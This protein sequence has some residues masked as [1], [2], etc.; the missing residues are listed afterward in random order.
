MSAELSTGQATRQDGADK[1]ETKPCTLYVLRCGLKRRY[2]KTCS[3]KTRKGKE[4][5]HS[6]FADGKCLIG[7]GMCVPVTSNFYSYYTAT[8]VG[9]QVPSVL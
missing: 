7:A 5:R 2:V 9:S 3:Y 8:A 4:K 6:P 1:P